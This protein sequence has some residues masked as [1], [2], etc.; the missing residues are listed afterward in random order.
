MPLERAPGLLIAVAGSDPS[1]GAGLQSDLQTFAAAGALGS[2]VPTA[3]TVQDGR[4]ARAVQAL[5]PEKV[6]EALSAALGGASPGAV[7]VGLLPTVAL[8]E[9][10]ALVLAER[11]HWPVVLD[12]VLAA[13]AGVPLCQAGVAPALARHLAPLTDLWTPNLPEAAEFLGCAPETVV[14]EPEAACRRLLES[15]ARAVLLKGGH[16]TGPDSVD[17]FFDGERATTLSA[18]RVLGV[19]VRGTGCALSSWAAARLA[20][21]DAPLE[22][23]RAA[24]AYVHRAIEG[25]LAWARTDEAV[26]LDRLHPLRERE[27][28]A[29]T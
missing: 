23:A 27:N 17:W 26:L 3:W 16:G 7:K 12:P 22:A 24:K 8:V 14:R 21:G 1:G 20:A 13:S 11:P 18:P 5:A 4:G 28:P 6:A 15:G 25:A 2:A 9:A 29:R 19:R 10:V